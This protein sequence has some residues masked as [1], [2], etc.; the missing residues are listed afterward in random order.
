MTRLGAALWATAADGAAARG[1]LWAMAAVG[2]AAPVKVPLIN[3]SGPIKLFTCMTK[4]A[5]WFCT[6][7]KYN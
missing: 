6:V 3:W 2:A 4:R 7:S 1:P 5:G